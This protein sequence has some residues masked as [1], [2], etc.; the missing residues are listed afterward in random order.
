MSMTTDSS[1]VHYDVTVHPERHELAVRMRL[2]GAVATGQIRLEIPTWVPGDYS[3]APLARDLFD[4]RASDTAS[5]APLALSRDGWQAFHIE[6]GSGDVTVSYRAWAY[7][8][9]LGEPSGIVDNEY[10]V[11]MGA[12]Y[13]HSPAYLGPCTVGYAL[14]AD[15]QGRVHHPSGAVE[16]GL[17]TWRYPSYEVL[18]D[19]PVVMGRYE[20]LERTVHG[21]PFYFTFV[22]GGVGFAEGAP[23]FVD[24]VAAV[25]AGFHQVFGGF[26]FQDYTFVLSLNPSNEWGLEHLTST[27]CG[28]DPDVFVDADKNAVGV[29]VCAHELFHAWNVRRLRP[30]PLMHLDRELSSGSFSDGLWMAEGFTR[31]YEFLSCTRAGVYG[32]GQFFSA[33]VGYLEHLRAVPAYERVSGADS[34]LATYLNHSPKYPGRPA[35]CI[36]YYDKGMLIAF[37]AD[38]TLRL[39]SATQSLDSAFRGFY[40]EY[41]SGGPG[42]AGYTVADTVAYFNGQRAGLGTLIEAAVRHPAGLTTEAL[43][44]QLGFVVLHE[45]VNQLGVMFLNDGAPTIYNVLDDTPAGRSGLAPQDV[46]TGVNGFNFTPAALAWAAAQPEALTLDVKRGHRRLAFTVTPAPKRKIGKLLWN[47]S[48]A[49]AERLQAWLGVPF[50]FAPGQSIDLDFYENFHGIETVM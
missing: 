46:I 39:G 18:L 26:P 11:L 6:G 5:G 4:V 33:V 32:A 12:R 1:D 36:D 20:L 48:T 37:G 9:E 13:L 45:T 8:P 2:T 47:G 40:E 34:S 10:A 31:Y 41:V 14:P 30:A 19:T 24:S 7:A 17:N 50:T 42:Y 15:W 28:L 44:E 3:F 25:A 27:M 23:A 21:T 49:Q 38:A 22:D 43:L 29:R 16:T 35:N